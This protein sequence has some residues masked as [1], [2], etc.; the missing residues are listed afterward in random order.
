MSPF[1]IEE[2]HL[3]PSNQELVCFFLFWEL[4]PPHPKTEPETSRNERQMLYPGA[5][6]PA[7]DIV[8][9]KVFLLSAQA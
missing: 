8:F 1:S 7:L 6:A 3:L 5:A 2:A 4:P 9:K